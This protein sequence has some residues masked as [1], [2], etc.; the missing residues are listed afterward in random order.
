[1]G[2]D[3]NALLTDKRVIHILTSS[4]DGCG[5]I[6]LDNQDGLPSVIETASAE[7]KG[8]PVMYRV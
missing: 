2:V 6:R 8:F 7:D 5:V 1:M 4:V 3:V